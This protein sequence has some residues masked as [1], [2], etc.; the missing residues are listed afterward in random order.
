MDVKKSGLTADTRMLD[1][2]RGVPFPGLQKYSIDH[3]LWPLTELSSIE[4]EIK[5]NV[6]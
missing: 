5:E 3:F 4:F 2:E 1:I 6:E